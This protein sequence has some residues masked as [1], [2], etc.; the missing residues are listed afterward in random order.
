MGAVLDRTVHNSYFDEM[1]SLV[2]PNHKI[3]AN[4]LPNS[5]I[6]QFAFLGKAEVAVLRASGMTSAQLR[7]ANDDAAVALDPNN[8]DAVRKRQ[9]VFVI[10]CLTA[11]DL[12]SPQ[13]IQQRI[14]SRTTEVELWDIEKRRSELE[15]K[16]RPI[17]P[18]VLTPTSDTDPGDGFSTDI[19]TVAGTF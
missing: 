7:P 19:I 18:A 16:I 15:D 12:L 6:D 3:D 4:L 17:L 9:L 10:Q 13:I 5:L 2:N 1:R 14:L 8:A 11:M